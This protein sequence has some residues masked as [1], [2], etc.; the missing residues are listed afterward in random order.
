MATAQA[1]ILSLVE[2]MATVSMKHRFWH[3]E[4]LVLEFSGVA[5]VQSCTDPAC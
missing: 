3:T 5:V 1:E 4:C 2:Y